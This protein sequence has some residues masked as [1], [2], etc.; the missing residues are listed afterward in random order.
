M[1]AK[2]SWHRYKK[3]LITLKVAKRKL[4]TN[5]NIKITKVVYNNSSIL[6]F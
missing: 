4:K 1:I 6:F 3:R 5:K 2:A